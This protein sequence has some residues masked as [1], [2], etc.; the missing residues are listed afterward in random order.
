MESQG[1]GNEESMKTKF[2]RIY[3]DKDGSQWWIIDNG[4]CH[5][6][7][8]VRWVRFMGS[9]A[10]SAGN[11]NIPLGSDKEEPLI[12]FQCDAVAT[13]EDGGVIFSEN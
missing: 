4:T 9:V 5:Q 13:F 11:W 6:S 1:I 10:Y 12:W 3:Q 7:M 2:W 8:K